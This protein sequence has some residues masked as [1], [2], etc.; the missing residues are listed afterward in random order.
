MEN[1]I[2]SKIAKRKKKPPKAPI[3]VHGP[4]NITAY[5]GDR[6]ELLCQT[7]GRPRPKI[8]WESRRIGE[9]PK[10]G[11]SYRVHK[12]GSLIFR[13]IE[14]QHESIYTCVAMNVVGSTKSYPARITVEGNIDKKF[15]ENLP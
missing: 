10:V 2:N 13:R 5:Y 3:I 11:P 8:L 4:L 9:M 7:E 15:I 12:N 6:I 1:D 14:K